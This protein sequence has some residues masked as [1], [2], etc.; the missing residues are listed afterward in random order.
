MKRYIGLHVVSII[1]TI[2]ATVLCGIMVVDF[3]TASEGLEQAASLTVGIIF[4]MFGA[5]AYL[6]AM[7]FG[8]IGWGLTR[9]QG[10][11]NAL[12]VVETL[13]PIVLAVAVFL[14]Y[15]I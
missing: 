4:A 2:L 3:L 8:A 6:V 10:R 5:G 1:L 7:I 9:R 11:T 13:L 12:F 15:L 14:I